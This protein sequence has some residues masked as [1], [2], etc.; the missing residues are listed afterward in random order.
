MAWD[1]VVPEL[2]QTNTPTVDEDVHTYTEGS[3]S[4]TP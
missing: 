1:L 4:A 2:E 3:I